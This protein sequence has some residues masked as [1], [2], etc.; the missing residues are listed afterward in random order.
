MREREKE[1]GGEEK[2]D[3]LWFIVSIKES[4]GGKKNYDSCFT[5]CMLLS[6]QECKST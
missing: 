5:I 6:Q 4:Q 2:K 1:R 3:Q